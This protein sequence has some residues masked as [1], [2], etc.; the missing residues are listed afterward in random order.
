MVTILLMIILFVILIFP[1]E[2]GHFL[3]AKA[4]GVQV[5]E[6]AFGMGPAIW[7]KQG[8]ETLYSI[9]AI[10]VGGYCAMEGEDKEESEDN[11][12]AFNNKKWWQK[13]IVLFAGALM[14]ILIAILAF[15]IVFG[16]K[17]VPGTSIDSVLKGSPAE[18]AGVKQ[19]DIIE[20]IDGKNIERFADISENIASDSEIKVTV[21]RNEKDVT[22]TIVP[23]KEK[24]TG[25]YVIGIIPKVSHNPFS[26]L[27]Y[28]VIATGKTTGMIFGALKNII[29]GGGMSQVSGPVGMA[30]LISKT[31]G[32]GVLYF[33]YLLAIISVN[34]AVFNLLPFP[35]LDGGRIIFVFIRMVTGKAIT[36]EIEGK[37]HAIGIILL[38]T[39]MV[40]ATYNDVLRL[41]KK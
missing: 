21:Q 1:H 9:R 29:A 24:E 31:K 19:G 3:A 23:E 22:L 26:A 32:Y 2:L 7:Q 41:I 13:I 17:G 15:A 30:S 16:V 12:R 4:C 10:P 34:L 39:L 35:A 36:D 38:L 40:F 6:F 27:K 11:D 18:K 8:K 5:N 37:V 33:I 25:R 28:G 20:V 14:N